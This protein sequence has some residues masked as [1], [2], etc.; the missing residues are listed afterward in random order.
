MK[1]TIC[2]NGTCKKGIATKMFQKS[3]S[4]IIL[5]NV[6]AMICDNCGT[7]FFDA[8]T[9]AKMLNKVRQLRKHGSE[10]EIINLKAVA[11]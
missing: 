2:R 8:E 3:N 1:C 10:L 7:K 6:D 5:K 4:I 11:A 9:S